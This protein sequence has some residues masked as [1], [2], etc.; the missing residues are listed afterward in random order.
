MADNQPPI[1]PAAPPV[2]KLPDARENTTGQTTCS[3][4]CNLPHGL[5][6]AWKGRKATFNGANH[7]RAIDTDTTRSGRWGITHGVPEEWYDD[8]VKTS[9]HPAVRNNHFLKNTRAK[10]EDHANRTADAIKTGTDPIVPDA[11]GNGV[12]TRDDDEG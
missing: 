5:T 8:W 2:A 1:P 4:A 7:A 6:V 3:V 9:N 10:I 11:P 12:E